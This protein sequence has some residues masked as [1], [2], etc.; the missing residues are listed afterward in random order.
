MTANPLLGDR[1]PVW[2]ELDELLDKPEFDPGIAG[3]AATYQ[4][5][6][7][8]GRMLGPARKLYHA[9]GRLLA[10]MEWAG[11]VDPAMMHAAMV[12]YGVAGSTLV[13]RGQPNNDLDRL[14]AEFDTMDAPGVI[15]ATELGRGGSQVNIRTEARYD[16]DRRAFTLYTPDD[17]SLKIMPNV[18]WTGLPRTAVVI[19]RLVAGGSDHGVH[20]FAFRFPHSRA[21]IAVLPGG[22]PVPLDYSVIRFRHAEIPFGYWLS[23]TATITESGVDDPLTPHQRLARSL[24]GVNTAVTSATVALASAARATV[25]IAARYNAQRIIGYPGQ[26]ALRFST[27]RTALASA[28]ARVYATTCYVEKIRRDF[29]DER[30]TAKAIDAPRPDETAGYAPWLAANRDRTLAKAAA[31]LAVESVGATCRRLCGFQGVLHTNRIT[32]YE[33]M[34]RSFHA[35]GGDTRLLLLEAGKQLLDSNDAPTVPGSGLVDARSVLRLVSVQERVLIDQL[36]HRVDRS[37]PNDHLG[38]IEHLAQAHLWRRILQEFETAASAA[39]GRWRTLLDAARHLYGL[40][41]LLDSAAWHLNRG[42]LRPGDADIVRRAHTAAVDQVIR[43]L[44]PLIDGLAV[45][46]GRV[47]GFIGQA[48]YVDRVASLIRVASGVEQ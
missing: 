42:S 8:F 16:H 20:A 12:H 31:T 43:Y 33:D 48:D 47:G 26:P 18:G 35:A 10:G 3:V 9:P 37:D 36:R 34:A 7:A 28:I 5:L 41:V 29:I 46:S 22:A 30:G 32:V 13:E 23:D 25:A 38:E 6:R 19:A 40:D 21:Q 44:N 2:A 39:A 11:I 45:P 14:V 4:R 17:A 15:V 24:G 27:H 1:M